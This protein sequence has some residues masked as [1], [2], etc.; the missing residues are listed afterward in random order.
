M[1]AVEMGVWLEL[2]IIKKGVGKSITSKKTEA[3]DA[4]VSSLEP[5]HVLNE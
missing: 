1:S 4:Y 2:R 3:I 5:H